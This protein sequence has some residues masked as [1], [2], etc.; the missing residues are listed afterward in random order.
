MG[1]LAVGGSTQSQPSARASLG[2]SVRNLPAG[3]RRVTSSVEHPYQHHR[4][5]N[6]FSNSSTS[7]LPSASSSP[8]VQRNHQSARVRSTPQDSAVSKPSTN[9]LDRSRRRSDLLA[10]QAC[11]V[12]CLAGS[13]QGP[14]PKS[15]TTGMRAG[16]GQKD[17]EPDPL[18]DAIVRFCM[19]RPLIRHSLTKLP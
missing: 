19:N 5:S 1:S 15:V 8:Q 6:E 18:H 13:I 14:P 10:Q 11:G 9:E 7:T 4:I 2:G 3:Q 16:D 12:S 17:L